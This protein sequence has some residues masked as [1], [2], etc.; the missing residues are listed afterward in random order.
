MARARLSDAVAVWSRPDH[1]LLDGTWES[2]RLAAL[3]QLDERRQ[4]MPPRLDPPP[5][6]GLRPTHD[7]VFVDRHPRWSLETANTHQLIAFKLATGSE[8]A[9]LIACLMDRD[10]LAF[11]LAE[12]YLEI[13]LVIHQGRIDVIE[14]FLPQHQE[15]ALRSP[16]SQRHAPPINYGERFTLRLISLKARP[17]ELQIELTSGDRINARD[18]DTQPVKDGL[19]AF[20]GLPNAHGELAILKFHHGP[21]VSRFPAGDAKR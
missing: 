20:A 15:P 16:I 12:F 4:R 2:K 18:F 5:A 7:L 11:Y 13:S 1:G 19:L 10:G 3:K 21:A 8:E 6:W 14:H 17:R 9:M